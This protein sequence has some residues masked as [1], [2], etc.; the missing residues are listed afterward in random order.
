VKRVP[1]EAIGRAG[2]VGIKWTDRRGRIQADTRVVAV[3][4][5]AITAKMSRFGSLVWV[6]KLSSGAPVPNAVVS[7]L[8]KGRGSVFTGSTDKSGLLAIP[9][10]SYV[11]VNQDGSFD[12]RTIVVA[13]AGEDWSFRPVDDAIDM[14]RY[15][16]PSDPAG[17]MPAVGMLFTDRGVYRPGETVKLKGIFRKPTP[18]GSETPVGRELDVE[19]YDGNGDKFLKQR[20]RLD[21]FGEATLDL[22]IPATAHL[23]GAHVR[24][25][26]VEGPKKPDEEPQHAVTTTFQLAAYKAAE[27]KVAVEPDKPQYIRGE[28]LA[29]TTRGEY[30][31][32]APLASAR[33][34]WN[35]TRGPGFFAPPGAE[36]LIL[37]DERYA[38]DHMDAS[39]R[40]GQFQSGDGALDAKGTFA[41]G[42]A[43]AMP[44]QRGAEVV[45]IEGEAEDVSRQTI[46]GRSSV[47]VHPG[48]FYVAMKP[49]PEMF[50]SKGATVKPEL[51]AVEPSGRKRPGV[52]LHV[53][54]IRRTWQTA[55]AAGG[56]YESKAIDKVISSCDVATTG[57]LTGCNLHVSDAG[58]FILRATG[59]DP[60]GNS[61]S[62]STSLYAL[63]DS[64]TLGWLIGDSTKLELVSDKKSYEVGD[65]AKI[66]VKSP[67]KEAEALITVERA[68]V[69]KQEYRAVVGATPTVQI[70]VTEEMRPNAFV[71]VQLVRG[72]TKAPPAKG[73]DAFGP[74]FRL[75]YAELRIN[76]EAK[77]LKV[78]V[79]PSKKELRPGEEL[80]VDLTVTDRHGKPAK[81]EV[82]F[83]AVDEGVL[84]LTGYKTP[85]PIPAFATPRALA[86]FGLE[87]RTA[88]AK[89]FLSSRQGPGTDKGGEGGGGG[90]MRADF[91]ATAHFEPSLITNPD[92][93][94]RVRFKLPDSLTTYRLMAVVA[95][96]D[97]RFGFGESQVVTSR[98][99]MARPAMPRFFRAG[100]GADA[101]I[102]LSSKGLPQSEVEVSILA[103]G[104]RVAGDA[105]RVV[106]L[107]ANGNMEIRW[108]IS[109]PDV[110]FASFT[111]RAS[112]GKEVDIVTVTREVKVPLSMEAVALYGETTE[113]AAEKLGDLRAMRSDVG[114][115][116][117]RVASTALVGLGGGVEQ[118]VEYPYGCTEQLVSRL[119]PILPL[120][121]LAMDYQVKLPPNLDRVAD[122][123]IA[124]V[125]MNQHGSGGFGYW[126]D[127]PEPSVWV[128]AYAVWA[129][130]IA[131]KT[132]RPVP[133][134]PLERGI[135][136]LRG[137]LQK[138]HHTELLGLAE[139][140]FIVDVLASTGKPD[141]GYTTGLYEQRAKM[142]LFAKALLLHAI[143]ISKMDAKMVQELTRDIESHVQL[144]PSGA[145]IVENA[146]D[147]YA[148]LLDSTARTVAMSLR[149]VSAQGKHPLSPRL[150]RGLLGMRAHGKWKSTQEAAW[151]LLA[152]DDYR[153]VEEKEEPDFDANIFLGNQ[154]V[155]SVPFHERNAIEKTM[156]LDAPSV[157][158]K[159]G[160]TMAFQ[161]QGKGRLFYEARLRYA[162][163][164]LPSD[165]LD[166][167]FFVKKVMRTVKPEA[168]GDALKTLP[169]STINAVRPS[170]LVLV[171]LLVVASGPR[172]HVVVEDPLPAGLEAVQASFETTSRT[173][174]VA[175]PGGQGDE[176]DDRASDYDARG[177]GKA[178]NFAWYHREIH[179]DK[180]LT[181]VEHMPAGMY[182]YRYLARATTMGRFVVPPTRA[183]CMYEP[184]IF[185]RTGATVFEVK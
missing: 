89:T 83:Y 29:F 95:A 157:F 63:G 93:K 62:S 77:R 182:H 7:V 166:R 172:E 112:S 33:L 114:G 183:E 116:D 131:K 97:D 55:L 147:A 51:L 126:P 45:T 84:M 30:L 158:G 103:K 99:L 16:V 43:L 21:A 151:A 176:E 58:Y 27:F 25:E 168:I 108:P 135:R 124:K 22:H 96:E 74:A 28:K 141:P 137:E 32:G 159:Q 53:E 144:T 113:A 134:D 35:I 100:D 24:A 136:F 87:S 138:K 69:Y 86:V 143:V 132:G 91:R 61:V 79:A 146:G 12:N 175:D 169:S 66:L 20:V 23:G 3:T 10:G 148:E 184:A 42:A 65:T 56:H 59:K 60:R 31:F 115:L 118:L 17:K 155:L 129:L 152:L 164:E 98:P 120:R 128:S 48:E 52:T 90:N 38:A 170:D 167:G 67:F 54:L 78:A 50:V 64:T 145:T 178:Y 107:P 92:G 72:R 162:K 34:R 119:V 1:L 102:I 76:P 104:A 82:T 142:P 8:V 75:G 47:I 179:D 4:D 105:K 49:L 140:A 80:D 185:G 122:E 13:R 18:K 173:Y 5:L 149:A 133:S 41:G 11:P 37:D 177:A 2:L 153:K 154:Q 174:D 15:D 181:F 123:A 109:T 73:T 57:D 40:G 6:T 101:G 125:L 130:D 68:G 39:P 81:A 26:M 36:E 46:A 165:P 70:P 110:G 106:T 127:S 44:N 111:F 161:V 156:T 14:W 150:A 160:Q 163:K 180:V 94:T 139:R 121:K 71:S 117:L 171:D 9:Q 19:A 88:L 85:D